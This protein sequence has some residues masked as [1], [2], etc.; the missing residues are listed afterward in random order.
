MRAPR[1]G[2]Q[3]NILY[4]VH[5]VP[6]PPDKGDRIRAFHLLRFLAQHAAVH[7]ACLA[8]EPL[9]DG[10]VESLGKYAARVAVFPVG[11]WSRRLRILRS[12][13]CGHTAT[14]GAFSSAALRA[15]LRA[16]SGAMTRRRA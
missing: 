16:A 6:Y 1:G 4:L 14:E 9:G 3:P 5:R 11:G 7:V 2:P 8:D 12:L 10:V 13:A 15:G